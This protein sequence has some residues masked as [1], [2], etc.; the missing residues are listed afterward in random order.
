MKIVFMGTPEFAVYALRALLDAGQDVVC[1]LTQ[2]DKPKGRG[3]VMTPS[4]VKAF[5]LEKGLRVETPATLR[6]EEAK[7]FLKSF[8]AD[9]FVVAAYGKI[10]PKAILDI[11][12]MGC[13]NVHA[14]LLPAW[15]GAAPIQRALMNGDRVGGVTM[16]YMDEGMDTGDIILQKQTDIPETMNAGEFHDALAELGAEALREFLRL[17]ETGE[18]PR[19]K[20]GD[21]FTLAAKITAEDQFVSFAETAEQTH[22]RI[23]GLSPAPSAYAMLNGKRVKLYA[24]LI[25]KGNGEPGTVLSMGKNGIEVACAQGSVFLTS[26]QPEGKGRMDGASFANGLRGRDGLKFNG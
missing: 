16:M 25:G 20:Q 4:D 9:L 2:P 17:A 22:N 19:K 14:S 1:V 3:Y 18:I 15:R 5:A 26:L 12:P 21:T 7:A 10:L 11:P 8:D 13:V 6:T 23:R 24:S